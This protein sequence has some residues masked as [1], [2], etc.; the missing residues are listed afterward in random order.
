MNFPTQKELTQIW[1]RQKK[2]GDA[3][4]MM[5]DTSSAMPKPGNFYTVSADFKRGDQ[6]WTEEFW[7]V[8]SING[9]NAFV[10]IHRRHGDPVQMFFEI[11]DRAWYTANDAWALK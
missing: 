3:A 2:N 7:E 8:L 6:S 5:A 9:P 1:D 4:R 10:R 11:A